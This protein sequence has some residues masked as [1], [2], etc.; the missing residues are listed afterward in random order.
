MRHLVR[1]TL[2]VLS[3]SMSFAVAA[4]SDEAPFTEGSVVHMTFV[5]TRS[6]GDEKYMKFLDT[7]WKS[8]NEAAKKDGLILSY[9]VLGAPATNKDDWNLC[10]VV[11]YKN[12]AAMDGLETKYR[13]LMEKQVGSIEKAEE[14]AGK[15]EEIRDVLGEKLCRELILK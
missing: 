8:L 9:R 4:R 6:G 13:A 10:L 15:R 12:M 11:E 1:A 7:T 5:R 3:M 2:V 14:Q